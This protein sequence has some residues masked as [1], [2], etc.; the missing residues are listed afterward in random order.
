MDCYFHVDIKKGQE[1]MAELNKGLWVKK[2]R[3]EGEKKKRSGDE[4]TKILIH[5]RERERVMN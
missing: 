1:I 4:E 2:R 3:K 5:T